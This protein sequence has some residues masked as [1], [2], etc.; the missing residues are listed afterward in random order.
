MVAHESHLYPHLSARENLIFA[1]RMHDVPRPA[2]RAGQLIDGA[3]LQ[4]Y[5]DCLSAKLSRGMQQRVAVARALVH[6][7]PILLLDEPFGGL[8][9]AA[10]AWL[11]ALLS[12]LRARKRTVCFITHDREMART[13]ADKV[14]RLQSGRLEHDA[15]RRTVFA[16]QMPP[17]RAA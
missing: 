2:E 1:A 10:T 15:C 9:E 11:T 6:D 13:L 16:A 8:D 7:P 5:A 3:G 12:D 4:R 14:F 17:V